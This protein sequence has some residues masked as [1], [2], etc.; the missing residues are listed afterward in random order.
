MSSTESVPLHV[1]LEQEQSQAVYGLR[2]ILKAAFIGEVDFSEEILEAAEPDRKLAQTLQTVI[3]EEVDFADDILAALPDAGLT[4]ALH[5][6]VA[7]EVDFADD[8]LAALPDAKLT[9]ALQAA[10]A[11][12]IDFADDI[13]AA[14]PDAKLTHALQ[15]AVAEEIDFADDILAALPD[16]KLTHA[17]QTAVAEEVDF[18]ANIMAAISPSRSQSIRTSSQ[19]PEAPLSRPAP[20]RHRFLRAASLVAA[21][22]AA[23]LALVV[24][25]WPP[26]PIAPEP[27][28]LLDHNEAQVEDIAFAASAVQVM[29]FEE[30]GP[31][32]ILVDEGEPSNNQVPL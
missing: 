30:D 14:L 28:A 23:L 19:Q 1:L 4:H 5:A 17:L 16:A 21:P 26:A 10:V 24:L 6:V 9:H 29:Q 13:F 32:F 3:A 25:F 31:T 8:I 11:E 12:E 27:F 18:S 22:V 15:V 7:E 20:A 2:S